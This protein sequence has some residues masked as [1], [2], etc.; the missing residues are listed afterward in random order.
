MPKYVRLSVTTIERFRRY[1]EFDYISEEQMVESIKGAFTRNAKMDYGEDFGNY[2]ENPSLA[3][4]LPDGGRRMPGYNT[5]LAPKIVEKANEYIS[6][7]QSPVFE[8]P[9]RSMY[10]FTNLPPIIISGRIDVAEGVL[11]RDIKTTSDFN[12]ESY[13]DS[14]QWKFYLDKTGQDKFVYDVFELKG[15]V[16]DPLFPK[17]KEKQVAEDCE[18]HSFALYTYPTLKQDCRSW[19]YEIM[20]FIT[21]K[22]L[23]DYVLKEFTEDLEFTPMVTDGRE[24]Y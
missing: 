21:R 15:K 22:G 18:F 7:L 1:K 6:A 17:D 12:Y 3:A 14:L 11:E 4:V 2:I 16:F 8:V 24:D 10:L 19:I 9:V 5:Y 13:E 20:G 23:M